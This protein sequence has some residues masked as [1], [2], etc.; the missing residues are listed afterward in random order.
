M[1][2]PENLNRCNKIAPNGA[3]NYKKISADPQKI[4]PGTKKSP[5]AVLSALVSHLG[6]SID[7]VR[8]T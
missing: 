7:K 6:G 4:R 3:Q 8:E 2:L 5:V 1:I